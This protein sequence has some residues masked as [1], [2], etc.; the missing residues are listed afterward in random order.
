MKQPD[1]ASNVWP[2]KVGILFVYWE[3][4]AEVKAC[5]NIL[6]K[7]ATNKTQK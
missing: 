4:I 1:P 6:F 2:E 5:V 7:P 3:G